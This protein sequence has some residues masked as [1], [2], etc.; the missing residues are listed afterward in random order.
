VLSVV[1][2]LNHGGYCLLCHGLNNSNVLW[3]TV[4]VTVCTFAASYFPHNARLAYKYILAFRH[5]YGKLRFCFSVFNFYLSLHVCQI[6]VWL[7][8]GHLGPIPCS[9]FG[10]VS[11]YHLF[12]IF[13]KELTSP[14]HKILN[15]LSWVKGDFCYFNVGIHI[16]NFSWKMWFR[17]F[18]NLADKVLAKHWSFDV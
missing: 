5:A 12:Q 10:N 8:I 2:C 17:I 9:N 14:V 7:W 16:L 6:R 4:A 11:C 18:V 15:F 3:H 13:Y 1:F